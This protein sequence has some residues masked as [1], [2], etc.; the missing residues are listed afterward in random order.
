MN[1]A[2]RRKARL[3]TVKL[4]PQDADTLARLIE[5]ASA[6]GEIGPPNWVEMVAQ[7]LRTGKY[8]GG[9]SGPAG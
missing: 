4:E 2:N 1:M 7:T 9:A 8:C 5:E 3:R 6:R